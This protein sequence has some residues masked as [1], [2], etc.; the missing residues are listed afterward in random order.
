MLR[1]KII[2][3]ADSKLSFDL[4]EKTP[5]A[6]MEYYNNNIPKDFTLAT[7][8]S[9]KAFQ[10]RYPSLFNTDGK[11]TIYKHRKKFMD[12]LATYRED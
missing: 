10:A 6:F 2:K 9:L 1:L 11:W 5:E 8:K 4:I 12:W 7:H 3:K